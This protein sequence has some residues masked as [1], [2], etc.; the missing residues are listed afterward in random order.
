MAEF[1]T[2][3]PENVVIGRGRSAAATRAPYIEA[4]ANN[5]AGR[6]ILSEGEK[7]ATV[8]RLLKEGADA[9]GKKIRAAYEND[10]NAV[11]WKTVN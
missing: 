10:E 9:A 3:S 2:L 8:R 4:V 1:E 6:V 11:Y 7:P 5:D